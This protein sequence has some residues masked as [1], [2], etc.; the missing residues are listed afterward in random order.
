MLND[1]RDIIGFL[2]D[3]R[4][5][6][7][8]PASVEMIETH[9]ALV[10]LAGQDVYKIK[11]AVRYSYMDFSTLERR[12]AACRREYEIN[13]P[14]APQIYLGVV[15]ITREDNGALALNGRG[16]AVEW[17][18][19]MRRFSQEDVLAERS[20]RGPLGGALAKALASAVHTFHA[21]APA[22]PAHDT[23]A[24]IQA[25]LRDVTVALRQAGGVCDDRRIAAFDAAC[26]SA[27]LSIAELL[28]RRARMGRV[29]RCHGDLHTGNIVLIDG[30][31]V[32]FD[33]LEFDEQLATIDTLYDLAFL[34][35]DLDHRGQRDAANAV[36]NRYLWLAHE[37]IDLEGLA[38]LPV[39]LALRAAIRAMVHAQRA[40]QEHG[41]V[42]HATEIEAQAYLDHALRLLQPAPPRLLLVGGLSGTG[43]STL[44]AQ[45]ATRIGRAPGAVHLRSDLE[46]K[47]LFGAAETERLPASAYTPDVTAKVYGILA[48][49]AAAALKA[50]H[51]VVADA[52]FARRSERELVRHTADELAIAVDGVWLEA[53]AETLM[54]R[55]AARTGDASDATPQVVAAQ[56]D[57]DIGDLDWQRVDA[58]GTPAE[59]LASALNVLGID[60]PHG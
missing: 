23:P 55:V 41:P 9:G 2:S 15:P 48:G 47:A 6:R 50:G 24:Q 7:P 16:P 52:V 57:Y 18:V 21:Q 53:P 37:M 51:S 4:T 32:L 38:A 31:P 40:A 17:A 58:S 8:A 49:K 43:K 27:I 33:A 60:A 14:G 12:R 25:V 42:R 39:F 22:S 5:Y 54:S 45:L 28:D 1:Q 13:A 11:R 44:A 56:L 20:L 59:T 34:L 29:R 36:L 35:M 46:R 30:Q 26:S 19:H 3:P 10:F